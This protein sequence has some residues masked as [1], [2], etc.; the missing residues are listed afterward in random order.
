MGK[1]PCLQIVTLKELHLNWQFGHDR[2]K[3]IKKSAS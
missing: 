1:A 3:F 2:L